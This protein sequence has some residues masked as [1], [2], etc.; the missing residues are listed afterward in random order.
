MLEP[1]NQRA[2]QPA[3]AAAA[4]AAVVA[5]GRSKG[6]PGPGFGFGFRS[7]GRWQRG[8][9]VATVALFGAGVWPG[10]GGA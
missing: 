2:L 7:A 9:S 8:L 3:A 6:G 10:R 5:S 4:A 1:A